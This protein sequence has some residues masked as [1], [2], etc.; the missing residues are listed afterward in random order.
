MSALS[1]VKPFAY[2]AGGKRGGGTATMGVR[3]GES[4]NIEVVGLEAREAPDTR[5]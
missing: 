5:V 1:V 2:K 4:L 3:E